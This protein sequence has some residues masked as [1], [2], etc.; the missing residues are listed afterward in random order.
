[1]SMFGSKDADEYIRRAVRTL[2]SDVDTTDEPDLAL[3]PTYFWASVSYSPKNVEFRGVRLGAPSKS[4]PWG[5]VVHHQKSSWPLTSMAYC[6]HGDAY[7]IVA[8]MVTEFYFSS[9]FAK[10][11]GIPNASAVLKRLGKPDRRKS[12]RTSSGKE[13]ILTYKKGHVRI[14][15]EPSGDVSIINIYGR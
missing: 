10:K 7:K 6:E 4:V 9:D 2:S 5:M 12:V 3:N 15:V 1:M 14:Q 8:G 11:A 13:T